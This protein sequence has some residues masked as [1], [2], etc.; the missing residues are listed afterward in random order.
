M[1]NELQVPDYLKGIVET[2]QSDASALQGT[3]S[4]VPRISLKGQKFSFIIDGDVEDKT[5]DPINVVIMGVQPDM[6]R[7]MCKTYYADGYNPE[8]SGPPDCSSSDGIK[9]DEW[10]SAPVSTSCA[11][12]EMNKWGSAIS[13]MT[14]KK[15][16]ACRDSKRLYVVKA[17]EIQNGTIFILNVTVSSL[18]A[19][20]EYGKYVGS[21]NIPLSAIVTKISMDEDS[22]FPRIDFEMLGFL[23][24]A[25]GTVAMERS[26][27]K[28]WDSNP[29]PALESSQEN[30]PSL[31]DQRS[32]Q[33][34][35]EAKQENSDGKDAPVI[36]DIDDILDQWG[37]NTEE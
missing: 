15:A 11:T 5:R 20:S 6:P 9:P 37:E 31:T 4:S 33:E 18:K 23:N 8:D 30:K 2:Q 10:V 12:C 16:K 26:S 17:D 7:L 32:E 3:V 29:K 1:S 19:L 24:E 21:H 22:D 28:E 27:K 36:K 13:K 14:Q 34:P 25:N 35:V